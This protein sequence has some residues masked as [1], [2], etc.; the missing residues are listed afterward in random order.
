M[1]IGCYRDQQIPGAGTN[2]VSIAFIAVL[3]IVAVIITKGRDAIFQKTGQFKI[4]TETRSADS[5]DVN[6]VFL[7]CPAIQAA[8]K[9]LDQNKL[10][11]PPRAAHVWP[12]QIPVRYYPVLS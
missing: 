10:S 1:W 8:I 11:I 12:A 9:G 3:L 4:T 5:D 6:S 2:H 7:R